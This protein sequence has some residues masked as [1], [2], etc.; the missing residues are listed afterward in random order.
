MS[1]IRKIVLTG[2]PCGGKTESL[3]YLKEKISENGYNVII[4]SEVATELANNGYTLERLGKEQYQ[5]AVL[6]WQLEKE[7]IYENMA[8]K[9]S[10]KTV[11][12]L[13]RGIIDCM[14]YTPKNMFKK[15]MQKTKISF[16][17]LYNRYDMIFHLTSIAKDKPEE[18][19]KTF[20]IARQENNYKEAIEIDDI[21]LKTWKKY[22]YN[23]VKVI[24][25][26][27][28]FNGKVERTAEAIN[29]YLDKS[30]NYEIEK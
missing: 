16:E 20:N 7:K 28:D 19:N 6:K 14:V 23:K 1:E 5:E 9:L 17:E 18:Y 25:N 27:T 10:G 30:N 29:N 11:L 13:D 2:G 12:L 15:I 21:T 24:D 3:K 4:I 8:K 26:S 22:Y